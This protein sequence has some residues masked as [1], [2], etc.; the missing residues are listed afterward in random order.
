MERV[1]RERAAIERGGKGR[2]KK[3]KN[4]NNKKL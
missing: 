4:K 2:S 3:K 1:G